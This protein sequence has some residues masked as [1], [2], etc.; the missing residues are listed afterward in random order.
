L[1]GVAVPLI[2]GSNKSRGLRFIVMIISNLFVVIKKK[3]LKKNFKRILL[4]MDGRVS[5]KDKVPD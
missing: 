2:S 3:S 4:E 1:V 5:E